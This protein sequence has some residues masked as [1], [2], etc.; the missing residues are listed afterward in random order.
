MAVAGCQIQG[1]KNP[2]L[3]WFDPVAQITKRQSAK[4]DIPLKAART[5][6]DLASRG[7]IAGWVLNVVNIEAIELASD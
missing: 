3:E 4:K 5:F 1:V 7:K 2:Q 6:L